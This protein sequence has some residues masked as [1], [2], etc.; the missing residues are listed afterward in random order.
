MLI[1]VSEQRLHAL[2]GMSA[3]EL[4]GTLT[5]EQIEDAGMEDFT[6]DGTC[7]SVIPKPSISRD[8][9]AVRD[10]L[11]ATHEYV[12]LEEAPSYE[13]EG[14]AL[15]W[16]GYELEAVRRRLVVFSRENWLALYPSITWYGSL[17]EPIVWHWG[18]CPVPRS[19]RVF[20]NLNV[21]MKPGRCIDGHGVTR[22]TTHDINR[23]LYVPWPEIERRIDAGTLQELAMLANCYA[24]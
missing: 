7:V 13:R 2:R 6:V 24:E 15:W 19:S 4:L 1:Q 11:A 21:N 14:S 10:A 17:L 20:S 8:G 22:R 5:Q 16:V 12:A 9:D 23:N 3:L 18:Q